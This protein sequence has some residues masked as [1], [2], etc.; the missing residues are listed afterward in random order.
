MIWFHLPNRG[1]ASPLNIDLKVFPLTFLPLKRI[2]HI[3]LPSCTVAGHDM[4]LIFKKEK[5]FL[6]LLIFPL[7][8]Q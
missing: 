8:Y 7:K 1:I 2:C 3:L 6:H 4:P 5:Q